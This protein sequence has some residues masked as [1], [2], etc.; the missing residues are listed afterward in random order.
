MEQGSKT[1]ADADLIQASLHNRLRRVDFHAERRQG[2]GRTR[3]AGNTSITMFGYRGAGGGADDCSRRTDVKR[4][5]PASTGSAGIDNIVAVDHHRG[6]VL[7][8]AA[9]GA[10]QFLDGFSFV[11]KS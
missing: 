11:V 9:R 8:E 4:A 1:K 10:C 5:Q 2:V 6:H 3:F 7:L